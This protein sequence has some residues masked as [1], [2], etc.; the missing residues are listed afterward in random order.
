MAILWRSINQM[1]LGLTS[2]HTGY[3]HFRHGLFILN[4]WCDLINVQSPI[5]RDAHSLSIR[6][7]GLYGLCSLLYNSGE[8]ILVGFLGHHFMLDC[9]LNGILLVGLYMSNYIS[10][11]SEK[12]S[13]MCDR[14]FDMLESLCGGFSK[15]SEIG[16][17]KIFKCQI[18]VPTV[19][20]LN[21]GQR[22]IYQYI[23]LTVF[24]ATRS[25]KQDGRVTA[26]YIFLESMTLCTTNLIYI[27]WNN[28][29]NLVGNT[30]LWQKW[31]AMWETIKDQLYR[32]I[33]LRWLALWQKIQE[34]ICEDYLQMPGGLEPNQ[35]HMRGYIGT[36]RLRFLEYGVFIFIQPDLIHVGQRRFIICGILVIAGDLVP[37]PTAPSG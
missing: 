11:L 35:Y 28:F 6:S 7:L 3:N 1:G 16:I 13:D 24:I 26:K 8:I 2:G 25:L 22:Q 17:R 12:C 27:I 31:L 4:I 36:H 23:L 34:K 10:Q 30:Q 5:D 37:V 21:Q 20:N 33:W 19:K 15:L 32:Q 18:H 14:A 29:D 9:V